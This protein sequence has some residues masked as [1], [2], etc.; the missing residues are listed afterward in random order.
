MFVR[1]KVNKSGIVSV[2]VIAKINGQSRLLKT[3]GSSRDKLVISELVRK[4]Q[5]YIDSYAD[6]QTLGFSED[7]QSV[8]SVFESIS[9]HTEVG[10]AMLLGKI[11]DEVGFDAIP[12]EIFRQLVMS[13]LRHPVSK[14][15]TSDYLDKYHELVYP[16]QQI[17]RYMD[18]FHTSQKEL[19]QQIS[20]THTLEILGGEVHVVFYDVTTLYFEI[21]QEDEIRR[22]GFSKEGKHQNPQIVLGL[23]VSKNGY[24]LAYDIFEGNKFEGH[25]M[26]PVIDSFKAKYRLKQLIII[27]DSGL[28]SNANIEELTHG[29]YEFILGARIKSEKRD[30]QRKIL[31]LNLRNGESAMIEKGDLRLVV[32]YAE[33]RAGKD[34]RN[35]EKGLRKLEKQ[36]K[37]GQLTKSN[38]NSRGYNKYL[39]MDGQVKITIDYTRFNEDALWDGLKGNLTNAK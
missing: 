2:Q 16:V 20:Y 11:F 30:I 25:T 31:A 27:A 36:I 34:R 23:L 39:K 33:S 22:T 6:Q 18:K 17:Y 15:R 10:T 1:E 14:L 3:I 5:E 9:S 12:Q 8:R 29:G 38:I 28:L 4:G 13:R 19:V 37:T 21:D 7:H 24:P 35:R 26:L 32:T